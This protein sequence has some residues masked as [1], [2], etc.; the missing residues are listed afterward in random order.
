MPKR[1]PAQTIT[2]VRSG[3]LV[4]PKIGEP[5]EFTADEIAQI[6]RLNAA[7]LSK[8]R[9]VAVA[10]E[11]DEPPVVAAEPAVANKP[12]AN[13]PAAAAK[14]AKAKASTEGL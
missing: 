2:V 6:E 9:V 11:D 3:K 13:K 5:F 4:N 14:G 8:T 10:D 1:V 7:A 12:A